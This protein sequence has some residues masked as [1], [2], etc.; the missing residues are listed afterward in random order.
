MRKHFGKAFCSLLFTAAFTSAQAAGPGV[1]PCGTQ[2]RWNETSPQAEAVLR[3]D[4]PD[5]IATHGLTPMERG[6]IVYDSNQGVCWLAD[7]NLAGDPEIR[8]ML[9]VSG[10]NPDGTMNWT[11]ALNFVN[12]LNTYNSGRGYMGHTNWQLPDTPLNDSTCSSNNNGNFGVACTGS[13][14]GNL[15]SI[16]LGRAF[17]NSVAPH[18]TDRV[19]P[20]LNLQPSLYWTLDQNSGGEVTFSFDTGLTGSNTTKYNYFHVLPMT[21]NAIGTPPEG[22]GVV[23]YTTGSAALKAVYDTNTGITWTLD[24]NL[25]AVDTFGLTG[26]TTIPSGLKPPS[27]TLTVPLVDADGTMLFSTADQP[28]GWLAAMNQSN[29]AGTNE[30]AL[31]HITDLQTLFRDLNL[32]AGD[33]RMLAQDRVGPFWHLQPFFY[34]ACE[35]DEPGNS[36]SPCNLNLHPG[37]PDFD[38]SFNFDNGFEGTDLEGKEF[39]VMVYFPATH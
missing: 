3:G 23:P 38:Y 15:Y 34:W 22:P 25:A 13:A 17:P 18:F 26:V 12:A 4:N 8:A 20:F 1:D 2:L 39:Y 7:A 32:E 14:L 16:G 11:A 5:P 27:P 36:Q 35:R 9:D 33:P 24:A 37:T 29:Y 30:W 10:I 19:S 21:V 28:G 31:P 6:R